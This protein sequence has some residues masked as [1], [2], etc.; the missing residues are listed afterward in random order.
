[1]PRAQNAHAM[2]NAG[3][4]FKLN[5]NNEVLEKPNIIFGGIKYDFVRILYFTYISSIYRFNYICFIMVSLKH[6]K[7]NF[8]YWTF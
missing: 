4:L 1:M 5:K 8:I 7:L 6:L 3:F 2:V